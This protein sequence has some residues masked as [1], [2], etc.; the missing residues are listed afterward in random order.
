MPAIQGLFAYL[1]PETF[2]PVSSVLATLAGLVL[3]FWRTGL[4]LV[5]KVFV[6]QVDRERTR[7]VPRPHFVAPRPVEVVISDGAGKP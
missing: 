7:L 5:V 1:G 4:R 2:L 6:G 3:M